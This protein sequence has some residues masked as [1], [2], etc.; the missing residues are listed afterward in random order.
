MKAI[1]RTITMLALTLVACMAPATA[2]A[3]TWHTTYT[4]AN[5]VGYI[6]GGSWCGM[7]YYLNR[8]TATTAY[9]GRSGAEVTLHPG[10]S[11]GIDTGTKRWN[12]EFGSGGNLVL[13]L[14]CYY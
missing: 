12:F 3:A 7:N 6:T 4:H 10:M 5:A 2:H 9:V 8:A 13:H 14:A 11:Y 1:R